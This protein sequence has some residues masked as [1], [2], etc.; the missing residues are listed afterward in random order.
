MRELKFI[1]SGQTVKQDP[2][3]DFS[4]LQPGT[5]GYLKASFT[6]DEA[7]NGCAK[8]AEFRTYLDSKPV[9]ERLVGD[10]CIIPEEVL[11]KKQFKVSVI[12]IRPG[13]RISTG[14]AEVKQNG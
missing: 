7:W 1:V 6:F 10:A 5:S 13:Y 3:C 8:I 4:G 14:N 9:P 11:A 12:G 2:L